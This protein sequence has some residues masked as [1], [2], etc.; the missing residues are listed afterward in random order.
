M[1]GFFMYYGL[2]FAQVRIVHAIARKHG[3]YI[4]SQ[5]SGTVCINSAPGKGK[6]YT[7]VR[8]IAAKFIAINRGI[9]KGQ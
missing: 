8:S 2:T 7:R 3:L 4:A 6:A 5:D 1:R 9:I